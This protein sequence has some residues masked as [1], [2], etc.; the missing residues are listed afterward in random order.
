[1]V[2]LMVILF[3]TK[4]FLL[5]HMYIDLLKLKAYKLFG[6]GDGGLSWL[7]FLKKPTCRS[8]IEVVTPLGS[9]PLSMQTTFAMTYSPQSFQLVC[10]QH[11]ITHPNSADSVS[12]SNLV[13]INP[14]PPN[15]TF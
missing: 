13:C 4:C 11:F 7:P 2:S 6:D 14:F 15:D 5:V 8:Y 10:V 3:S 1:M 12:T 9:I